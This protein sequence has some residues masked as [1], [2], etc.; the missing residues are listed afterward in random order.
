MAGKHREPRGAELADLPRRHDLR[1]DSQQATQ[2]G[3]ATQPRDVLCTAAAQA[4]A[5]VC[6][7]TAGGEKWP[8]D[9]QSEHAGRGGFTAGLR[10]AH[11]V[12]AGAHDAGGIAEQRG[13][14]RRRAAAPVAGSHVQHGFHGRRVIEQQAATAIGLQV[15]KPGRQGALTQ[16]FAGQGGRQAGAGQHSG[17]MLASKQQRAVVMPFFAVEQARCANRAVSCCGAH[18]RVSCPNCAPLVEAGRE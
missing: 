4:V 14:Q 1:G 8:L 15:N 12:C 5:A 13:Q 7:A 9:V 11:R 18:G 6:T 17:N 3:Q 16:R 10:G 2:V